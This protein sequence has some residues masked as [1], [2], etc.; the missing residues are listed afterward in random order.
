MNILILTPLY[1]I[2]GR[3]SLERNTEVIHH[4]AKYWVKEPDVKV[5]VVNTYLNPGRNM[6]FLLKKGELKNYLTPYDYETDGVKV[7]LT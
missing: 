6:T 2:V 7:H 3:E 5:R 4:F 1:K